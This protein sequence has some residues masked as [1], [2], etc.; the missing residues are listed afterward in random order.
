MNP[1]RMS[2][3]GAR[4]AVPA[5]YEVTKTYPQRGP[6]QQYRVA[7]ATSFPCFRCGRA[8]TSK[9][10]TVFR[11]DWN[12]LLCNGCYGR[13]LSLNDVRAGSQD[14]GEVVDALAAEL[15][16]LVSKEDAARSAE[17]LRMRERRLELLDSRSIRLLATAEY[18]ASHLAHATDLDWSA[19]VIGVCKAL[20]IEVINRVVEPLVVI[21]S[22]VDVRPD[23]SDKDIGRIAKF[24]AV[25][26]S[27]PPEIGTIRHFLQTAGNSKD[28]AATSPTLRMF[29]ELTRTWPHG[30]WLV[31]KAGAVAALER[32]TTEFRNPA[33]HT[34]ELGPKD[35]ARCVES[36]LGAEGFMWQ[37]LRATASR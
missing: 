34:E 21:A 11:G 30:D 26:T 35:Y 24:C 28:R 4:G 27:K 25:P 17:L 6:L 5:R 16:G 3:V 12:S 7:S 15:L 37:L 10:L 36:V 14:T 2:I 20:E 13:L 19:A 22:T 23:L 32:I 1:S 9:L 18:V 29:S 31:A 33:A 8:K